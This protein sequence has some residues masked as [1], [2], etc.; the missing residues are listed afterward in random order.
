MSKK[1]YPGLHV[2]DDGDGCD[3]FCRYLWAP[4]KECKLFKK[5]LLP[6]EAY[7]FRCA[8]CLSFEHTLNLDKAARDLGKE[9]TE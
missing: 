3:T 9:D 5:P 1:I 2:S 4:T 6:G 8:R 7:F